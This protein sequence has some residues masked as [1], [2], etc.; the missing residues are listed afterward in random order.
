MLMLMLMAVQVT[1]EFFPFATSGGIAG[2]A[3]VR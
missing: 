1:N 2:N 3:T